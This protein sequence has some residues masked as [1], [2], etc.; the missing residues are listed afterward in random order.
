MWQVL[1]TSCWVLRGLFRGTEEF[2]NLLFQLAFCN[3]V[4][5]GASILPFAFNREA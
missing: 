5:I 2:L 1:R 4:V 3:E